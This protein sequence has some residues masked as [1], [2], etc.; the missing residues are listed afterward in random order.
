MFR[1]MKSKLNKWSGIA[2]QRTKD[3][4]CNE[5]G[6]PTIEQLVILGIVIALAGIALATIFT[7]STDIIYGVEE[8]LDGV[9]DALDTANSGGR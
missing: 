6:G 3:A 5:R 8:G 2:V 7:S 1:K 4:I 9:L